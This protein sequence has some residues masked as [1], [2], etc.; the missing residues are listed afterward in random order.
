VAARLAEIHQWSVQGRLLASG[1]GSR[2]LFQPFMYLSPVPVPP[3]WQSAVS[4]R[5]AEG[6]TVMQHNG[7]LDV[8]LAVSS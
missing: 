8:Y 4:A 7:K 1:P 6:T 5:T 3:N 2:D